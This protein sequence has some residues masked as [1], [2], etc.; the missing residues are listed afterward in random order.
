MNGVIY[1]IA[2]DHLIEPLSVSVWTLRKYYS[3]PITV[4]TTPNLLK[5]IPFFNVVN[6]PGVEI[7]TLPNIDDLEK[8]LPHY[9]QKTWK[10]QHRIAKI[11]ALL[12]SPYSKSLWLDADT[13]IQSPIDELFQYDL[14]FTKIC[15]DNL[16]DIKI[17]DGHKVA[18]WTKNKL[19]KIGSYNWVF[20]MYV[21]EAFDQN[22]PLVNT[23]VVVIT[24]NHPM[25]IPWSLIGG[26]G[27]EYGV[28]DQ[29]AA[30]ALLHRYPD[31]MLLDHK[32]NAVRGLSGKWNNN[33]KH[34]R[35]YTTRSWYGSG[36]WKTALRAL[37][38]GIKTER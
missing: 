38:R 32:W 20:R 34:I 10:Y 24:K 26:V 7:Q 4:F 15:D 31:T 27:A 30:I 2:N 23:G 3:G 13:L 14:A 9:N 29:Y 6:N 11:I 19:K 1:Y 16:C 18:V 36:N 35:H 5:D 17:N 21:Q 12:C 8:R 28:G 33:D 37:N 22:I 25:L